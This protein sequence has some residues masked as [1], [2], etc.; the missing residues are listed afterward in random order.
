MAVLADLGVEGEGRS[1]NDRKKRG[2]LILYVA[3]P[4]LGLSQIHSTH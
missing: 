4:I 1:N 3:Y 2:F